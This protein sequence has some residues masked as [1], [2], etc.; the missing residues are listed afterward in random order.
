MDRLGLYV[1]QVEFSNPTTPQNLHQMAPLITK[2]AALILPDERL[3]AICY[4]C[5]A[6]SVL[7]A[8]HAIE[9]SVHSARPGV[10]VETPRAAAVQAY[11]C[12]HAVSD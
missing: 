8:D 12:G 6:A 5:T 4:C 7:I 1:T 10:P 11:F 3:D 9:A 2:A